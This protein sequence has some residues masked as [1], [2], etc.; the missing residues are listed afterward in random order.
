MISDLYSSFGV[1]RKY[2]S[3]NCSINL[4]EFILLLFIKDEYL[5]TLVRLWE[6]L[7]FWQDD[8]GWSRCHFMSV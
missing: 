6:L 8:N 1:R 7:S 3:Q 2:F 5:E 4:R